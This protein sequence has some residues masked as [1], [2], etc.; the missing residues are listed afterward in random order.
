[1]IER[2]GDVVCGLHHALGG[3]E[4]KFLGLASK[5]LST[6]SPSLASEPVAMVLVV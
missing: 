4:H 1:M 3:E 6:V 2:S 5:P